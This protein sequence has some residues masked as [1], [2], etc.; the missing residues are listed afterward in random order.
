MILADKILTLRKNNGWSQEDLAEKLNVSRQSI[1]KWESAAAI[2]DINR[3]LDMAKLFG[4]TT[5]YLLKDDL[6]T[7]VYSDTDDT[8]GK[9]ITVQEMNDYL[10]DNRQFAKRTAWGVLLSILSPIAVIELAGNSEAIGITESAGAAIGVA[11]L[12]LIV[13]AAVALFIISGTSMSRYHYLQNNNFELE[14]GAEGIVRERR[15]AFSKT[16]TVSIVIGVAL[17][18]LCALPLVVAGA[19]NAEESILIGLVAVLLAIVS[20]AAFMFVR[21]GVIMNGYNRLLSEGD[22]AK[23]QREQEEQHEKLGGIFWPLVVAVYL[24]WSFLSGRWGITWLIW[25]V[26]AFV[27]AALKA[28]I[29]AVKKK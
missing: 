5:D 16:H 14:Y 27:F 21:V 1:S 7:A 28:L 18:I 10:K 2:P 15:D 20:V 22:Y 25:P 23:P 8:A 6:D 4:V 26:A 3:I 29:S 9:R 12:L 24:V 11:A 19:L 17:C 13:A